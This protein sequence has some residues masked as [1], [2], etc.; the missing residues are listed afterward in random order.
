M[1]SVFTVSKKYCLVHF[2]LPVN[3]VLV[4]ASLKHYHP[5]T[6]QHPFVSH[7]NAPHNSFTLML[8]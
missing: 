6:D 1:Y 2:A 7:K 5:S 4:V 3:L 8:Y